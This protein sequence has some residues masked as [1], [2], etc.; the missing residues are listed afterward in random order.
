MSNAI[1][2]STTALGIFLAQTPAPPIGST[3]MLIELA[4][5]WGPLGLFAL[6]LW[7]ILAGRDKQIELSSVRLGPRQ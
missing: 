6:A 2:V 7:H 4:T 3:E 1:A 5:Q